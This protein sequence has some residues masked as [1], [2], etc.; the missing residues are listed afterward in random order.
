MSTGGEKVR[1]RDPP[2]QFLI[3]TEFILGTRYSSE[4][5]NMSNTDNSSA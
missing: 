3:M 4:T 2:E 1:Y 5:N